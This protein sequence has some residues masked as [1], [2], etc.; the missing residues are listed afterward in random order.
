MTHVNLTLVTELGRC[1]H[2]FC[3]S[4]LCPVRF[5][6]WPNS[7]SLQLGFSLQQ[8]SGVPAD[9]RY[10]PGVPNLVLSANIR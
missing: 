7:T 9:A 2:T 5:L 4:D 3:P 6:L 10:L 1:E 8:I